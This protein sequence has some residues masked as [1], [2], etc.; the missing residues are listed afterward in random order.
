MDSLG[1]GVWYWH[2]WLGVFD[3]LLH[4]LWEMCRRQFFGLQNFEQRGCSK[5]FKFKKELFKNED[6]V[7]GPWATNPPEFDYG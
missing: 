1:P 5:L 7:V 4:D 2:L 3:G 6:D